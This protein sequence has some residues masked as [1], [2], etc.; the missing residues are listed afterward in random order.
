ML[1]L[2]YLNYQETLTQ[3][4]FYKTYTDLISC[5]A[6][7]NKTIYSGNSID[8][9]YPAL[10]F[11]NDKIFLYTYENKNM[12]TSIIERVFEFW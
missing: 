5:N 10:I 2:L 4:K 12:K 7:N 8:A 1:S 11:E 9:G 6:Y 3:I